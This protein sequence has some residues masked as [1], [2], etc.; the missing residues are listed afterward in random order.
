MSYPTP[1]QRRAISDGY[2]ARNPQRFLGDPSPFLGWARR[3]F[4]TLPRPTLVLDLGSGPGRDARALAGPGVRVRAIDH[5]PLAIARGR[6]LPDPPAEL[7]FVEADLL[8]ALA[9][10]ETASIDAVY[11]HVVYMVFSDAELDRVAHEVARVLRPGGFH[12]FAV[13]STGD[14]IAAEGR[15]V[16]ADVRV[17]PPDTEPLRYFRAETLDRL[18]APGLARVVAEETPDRRVWYVSDRR[19]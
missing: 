13:R 17:R 10:T 9:A 6:A 11:A 8:P 4:D 15:E 19:T 18:R 5:A 3:W 7:E 16:A 12:L 1:A 2:Y 14:P